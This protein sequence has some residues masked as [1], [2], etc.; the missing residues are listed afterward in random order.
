MEVEERRLSQEERREPWDFEAEKRCLS[1][2]EKL[3]VPL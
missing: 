3:R 1:R 2:E